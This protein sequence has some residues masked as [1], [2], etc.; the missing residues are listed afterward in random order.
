VTRLCLKRTVFLTIV[1]V[2]LGIGC[3]AGD[4]KQTD[5]VGITIAKIVK[6]RDYTAQ[7]VVLAKKSFKEGTPEYNQAFK[8]YATAYSD[9]G[10]WDAYLAEALA[11]GRIKEK[12]PLPND[13]QYDDLS[14]SATKSATAFVSYV[15]SNTQG[16]SK[17]VVA[18]LSSLADLGLKLWT[19]IS[20]KNTKD[21]TAA[22]KRFSDATAWQSWVQITDGSAPKPA[23][24]QTDTTPA[25]TPPAAKPTSNDKAKSPN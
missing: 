18:I 11:T 12:K 19:G 23:P 14:S 22:S 1:V 2:A 8:L 13:S 4:A 17:A 3:F 5:S 15:D 21:R 10:A 6:A 20:D 9:Y 7:F 25:K 24:T 16:Q